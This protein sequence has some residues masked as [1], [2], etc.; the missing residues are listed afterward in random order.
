MSLVTFG[1]GIPFYRG[2]TTCCAPQDMDQNSYDSGACSTRST[3][4]AKTAKLGH[5]GCLSPVQNQGQWPS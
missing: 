2:A 4:P 3:G 1:Q 5:P